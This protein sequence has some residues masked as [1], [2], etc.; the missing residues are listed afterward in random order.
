[1]FFKKKTKE[2][3]LDVAATLSSLRELTKIGAD[4]AARKRQKEFLN[5]LLSEAKR[6]HSSYLFSRLCRGCSQNRVYYGFE[7][8]WGSPSGH[9][10]VL[11][12][13]EI[14]GYL[15]T[16]GI[17]HSIK[18]TELSDD[19]RTENYTHRVDIRLNWLQTEQ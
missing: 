16:L 11:A 19:E 1:M 10:T 14:C 17:T 2:D 6:G 18:H 13:D 4:K 15:D 7:H 12:Y 3:N 8:Y 5:E 9:D